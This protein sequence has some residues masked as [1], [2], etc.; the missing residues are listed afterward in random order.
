MPHF[1]RR[2][3]YNQTSAQKEHDKNVSVFAKGM[4]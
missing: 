1:E 4:Y 2:C 3:V